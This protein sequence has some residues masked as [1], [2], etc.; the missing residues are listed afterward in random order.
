MSAAIPPPCH[1]RSR[2]PP[3]RR[4]L[5]SATPTRSKPAARARSSRRRLAS[6][7][8]MLFAR[9]L[10]M[11]RPDCTAAGPSTCGTRGSSG[12]IYFPEVGGDLSRRAPV[13]ISTVNPA[14]GE[15]LE[16]FE[17][18]GEEGI[19]RK[20]Q[21]AADTFR[22][23]RKTSFAERAGW[24]MRAAEILEEEAEELGRIMKLEM[25][26]TYASAI[27]RSA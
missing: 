12:Y 8:P 24:L 14:T 26:K 16:T 13:A 3:S 11:S 21:L 25:G 17:A 1:R 19:E 27:A 10:P 18:L 5:A 4:G 9:S 15:E 7:G 22:E 20:L 2:S 6:A 23:Y